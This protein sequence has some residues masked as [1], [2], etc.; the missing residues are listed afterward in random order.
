[1]NRSEYT[2][3]VTF[4]LYYSPL[5]EFP[6]VPLVGALQTTP[7]RYMGS[8]RIHL[9]QGLYRTKHTLSLLKPGNRTCLV[10]LEPGFRTISVV[11]VHSVATAKYQ[12]S[13]LHPE[14]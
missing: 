8:R 12:A 10:D 13:E 11:S 9:P 5:A 1:M 4:R 6:T 3:V 2:I 7:L 14:T